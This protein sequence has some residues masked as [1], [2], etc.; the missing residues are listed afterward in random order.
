MIY[1]TSTAV[2]HSQRKPYKTK[3]CWHLFIKKI[4]LSTYYRPGTVLSMGKEYIGK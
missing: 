2:L 3:Y 1:L 4:F